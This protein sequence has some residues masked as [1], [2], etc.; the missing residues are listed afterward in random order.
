MKP[1][2]VLSSYLK[3]YYGTGKGQSGEYQYFGNGLWRSLGWEEVYIPTEL[4]PAKRM[5]IL[6]ANAPYDLVFTLP[7]FEKQPWLREAGAPILAWWSD[8]W[9][10]NWC[11]EWFDEDLQDFAAV[12]DPALLKMDKRVLLTNWAARREW[13]DGVELGQQAPQATFHGLLHGQR[14][15]LLAAIAERYPVAYTDT[16]EALLEPAEYYQQIA[17]S[18]FSLCLTASSQGPVQMKG[19]LMEPQLFGS[20]LVTQPVPRLEEYWSPG[21]ECI[22]F[23]TPAEAA[24]KM[25]SMSLERRLAMAARAKK[26]LLAEHLYSHRLKVLL[27]QIGF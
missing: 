15:Q 16:R 20:I 24:E 7:A 5:E 26:R 19:R 12:T 22:V 17:G 6:K 11:Q 8:G 13:L 25:R 3:S 23:N 2:R 4:E 14:R 1:R 9:R 21:H 27:Q 18:Q 10:A